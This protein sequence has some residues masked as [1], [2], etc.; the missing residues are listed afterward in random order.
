MRWQAGGTRADKAKA[1][2]LLHALANN[3]LAAH[4]LRAQAA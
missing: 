3:L 1:V 4:R 2:A